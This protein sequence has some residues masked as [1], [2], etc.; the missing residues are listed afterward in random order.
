MLGSLQQRLHRCGVQ[1][2]VLYGPSSDAEIEHSPREIP[3]WA[4]PV[5]TRVAFGGRICWQSAWP[6]ARQADLVITPQES[7]LLFNGV[8]SLLRPAPRWALWGQGRNFRAL[9]PGSSAERFKRWFSRRPDWWFASTDRSAEV[10]LAEGYPRNRI[11]VLN[12][13]QAMA[14][15]RERTEPMSVEGEGRAMHDLGIS[16][17]P[18]GL[19]LG[20]LGAETRVGFA[21]EAAARV[22]Q[23]VPGFQLV[24]VGEGPARAQVEDA[25]RQSRSEG[26]WILWLGHRSGAEKAALLRRADLL[27]NPGSVGQVMLESF[28][29]G[30]PLVTCELLSHGPERAYL[31]HG[32]NGWVSRD[33]V[34][35]FSNAVCW[36]LHNP[37]TRQRLREA[38]M[39]DAEVYTLEAMVRHFAD[40]I[41]SCLARPSRRS[42]PRVF[43]QASASA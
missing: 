13:A 21:L 16:P 17:G 28:V 34:G 27:I 29:A 9:S 41:M 11:T 22:R 14:P 43:S 10:V 37:A 12:H 26:G 33:D 20:R 7:R 4:E 25:V 30:T 39:R 35:S 3:E 40:G 32:E 6:A 23:Q 38:C 5:R 15:V 2:K 24:V 36:L 31:R 19:L 42:E 18:V 1:L 8:L